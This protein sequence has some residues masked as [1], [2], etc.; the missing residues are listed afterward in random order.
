MNDHDAQASFGKNV[1]LKKSNMSKAPPMLTAL[2]PAIRMI[3]SKE[4]L[5]SCSLIESEKIPGGISKALSGLQNMY[6]LKG[7]SMEEILDCL[8][9]KAVTLPAYLHIPNAGLLC[10]GRTRFEAGL[11]HTNA[12]RIAN[13]EKSVVQELPKAA[14]RLL[15]KIAVITGAAQGFGKGIAIDLFQEGA[16][17]VIADLNTDAGKALE[18]E[19]NK[20]PSANRAR[21][22]HA[23]VA[24][25]ESVQSLVRNTV[26]GF[27]G[28][29]IM[30]SNAG[31]LKAGGLDEMDPGTFELMTRVNYSGYFNCAKYA[32]EVM[33][34]QHQFH[35]EAFHDIIQVNSKSGLKGSKKNFAYAGGKFGGVGLTQSFALE[36]MPYRIKVNAVCPG[37]FFDGPLWSDPENGL[38]VQ[39]LA[40]G[41]VPGA[42]TIEDVKHHYESQVPAGRGCEVKDVT[43]AILYAIEQEYETGQ[44]IPVTGGQ[45]MLH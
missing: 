30:I 19:L 28:L 16:N 41:K 15:N 45:E 18:N 14:G 10:V 8:L 1:N 4:T 32:A 13:G 2:I 31:I 39:Y 38:F 11:L 17:I 22:I 24:D 3:L 44:A 6:G 29:D 25:P 27:G 36:L 9:K 12:L 33:Q 40:A 23:D 37:N 35:P 20:K 43:K 7:D 34:V 42:K 5:V 26:T 21:F